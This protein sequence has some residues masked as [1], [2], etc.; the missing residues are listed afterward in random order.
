MA[1]ESYLNYKERNSQHQNSMGIQQ[2]S[3]G[4]FTNLFQEFFSQ[5]S[6][7]RPLLSC[8]SCK[9]DL[10][11]SGNLVC[12][13]SGQLFSLFPFLSS[14]AL[15]CHPPG[16]GGSRHCCKGWE[17]CS[18][19]MLSIYR[20]LHGLI[21]VMPQVFTTHWVYCWR[22]KAIYWQPFLLISFFFPENYSGASRVVWQIT[23]FPLCMM[24]PI[25]FIK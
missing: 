8:S 24:F 13:L 22:H 14:C 15:P 18:E 12:L 9:V 2:I 25:D 16:D 3:L 5:F 10:R 4:V 21:E 20:N 23:L 7:P 19:I 17:Q 11:E 6:N 1:T